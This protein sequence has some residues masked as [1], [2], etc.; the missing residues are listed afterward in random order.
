M[1][2]VEKLVISGFHFQHVPYNEI[3]ICYLTLPF[4][5]H[6]SGLQFCREKKAT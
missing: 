3:N 2:H 1:C 4:Q 6:A 5:S